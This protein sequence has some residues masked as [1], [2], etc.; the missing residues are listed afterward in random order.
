MG[1]DGQQK[2]RKALLAQIFQ[3]NIRAQPGVEEKFH[4]QIL[5]HG[6]FPVDNFPGQAVARDPE[7]DHA[8]GAGL[9]L[10][11]AYPIAFQGQI[12]GGTHAPRSRPHDAYGLLLVGGLGGVFVL[13]PGQGPFRGKG[14]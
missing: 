6:D 12:I 11:H 1:A 13:A 10:E 2:G 8:A 5:Q 4:P 7:Q 9:G 14:F 3:G